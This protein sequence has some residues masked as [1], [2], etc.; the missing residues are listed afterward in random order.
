MISARLSLVLLLGSVLFLARDGA[1]C[2]PL[3]AGSG[4]LPWQPFFP[5][6]E[7]SEGSE[8]VRPTG[9]EPVT[10]ALGQ[11]CSIP[12]SH[13]RLRGAQAYSLVLIFPAEAQA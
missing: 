12:L 4:A 8:M 13:G 7:R 5:I 11:R 9:I 10:S 2:V 3:M 1:D 6:T